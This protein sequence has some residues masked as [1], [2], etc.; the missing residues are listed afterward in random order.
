[1]EQIS[2]SYERNPFTD[3]PT[4][5]L[6]MT[7]KINT[8][9]KFKTAKPELLNLPVLNKLQFSIAKKS[10]LLDDSSSDDFNSQLNIE[11]NEE[12]I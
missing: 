6:E 10:E 3:I 5:P 8:K 4:T 9:E 1:M 12:A 11:I 7:K 2:N